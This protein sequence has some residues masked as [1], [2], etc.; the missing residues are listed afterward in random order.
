MTA[1]EPKVTTTPNGYNPDVF[2]WLQG[3]GSAISWSID[4]IGGLDLRDLFAAV[5]LHGR[6]TRGHI[7]DGP[8]VAADA[9][10]IADAMLARRQ[11]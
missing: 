3:T 2:P 8:G 10:T 7:L 1:T 11:K 9:Y 5:Y 4:S 6:S